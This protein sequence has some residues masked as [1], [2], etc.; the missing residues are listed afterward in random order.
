MLVAQ[1]TCANKVVSGSFGSASDG[2][3]WGSPIGL[4]TSNNP[5]VGV[6]NSEGYVYSPNTSA[7]SYGVLLGSGAQAYAMKDASILVRFMFG[8]IAN[9]PQLHLIGRYINATNF[10]H[11]RF[12]GYDQRFEKMVAG[13]ATS[14]SLGSV[15]C[16]PNTWFWANLVMQGS[17]ISGTVWQDGTVQ[18]TTPTWS[19]TDTGIA[20][21]GYFGLYIVS[22]DTTLANGVQ[23]DNF[24]VSS[25]QTIT[26]C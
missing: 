20:I 14:S 3:S 9:G 10:Y 13:T 1:D 11:A 15:Y 24:S 18:P 5:V 4:L 7:A 6:N 12:D 22:A 19:V 2:S 25:L 23:F 26:T 16:G 8:S 17:T 21:P